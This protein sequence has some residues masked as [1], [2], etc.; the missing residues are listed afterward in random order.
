MALIIA[1]VTEMIAG[2]DHGIGSRMISAQIASDTTDL[3]IDLVVGALGYLAN[4][5]LRRLERWARRYA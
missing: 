3:A 5:S 1:V 4:L 2:A